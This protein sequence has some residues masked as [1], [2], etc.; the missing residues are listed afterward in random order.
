MSG[1]ADVITAV[2]LL[3]V[4][5]LG[6][7]AIWVAVINRTHASA[8]PYL[9]T[10]AITKL[11]FLVLLVPPALVAYWLLRAGAQLLMP[12]RVFTANASCTPGILA[13]EG[14]LAFCWLAAAA[15]LVRRLRWALRA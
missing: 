11:L 1:A 9:V 7:A 12:W 14:Y 2:V 13:G 6:H 3:I 15:T 5:T 8:W 4:A 10:K